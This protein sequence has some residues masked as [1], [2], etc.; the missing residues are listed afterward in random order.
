MVKPWV[1]QRIASD[2]SPAALRT[3]IEA[4][5]FALY[6]TF[7]V[8]PKCA[9]HDDPD[10]L[11]SLTDIP[12][13]LFN[14]VLRARLDPD[15]VDAAIQRVQAR[16][17]ANG[18]PL[19]WWTGPSTLPHDLPARLEAHGC[20]GHILP[21]MAADLLALPDMTRPPDELLITD[22]NDKGAAEIWC[23]VLC[24]G[25]G[26][27]SFVGDAFLDYM[28]SMGFARDAPFRHCLGW[29]DGQPVA[30]S[31]VFLGGGVAGIY[32]V[33]TIPGA[34]RRG[35]GTEMTLKALLDARA[36]GF[37]IGI[38]QSSEMGVNAYRA[39]GF[40]SVC[41]IGQFRWSGNG[42]PTPVVG[43]APIE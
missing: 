8:W 4:N 43:P 32:D 17:A 40:E 24:A 18:V 14:A 30:T 19:L 16:C 10:M 6:R 41:D 25:F 28:C 38:L 12:F 33:A 22:V 13:S 11:W 34:R 35:I 20:E 39:L 27:P 3:A 9:V 42:A 1:A 5:L 7:A 21:G 31:S 23:R 2:H 15:A 36:A 37:R 26:M 29:L